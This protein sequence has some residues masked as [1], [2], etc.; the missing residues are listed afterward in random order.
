MTRLDELGLFHMDL[1]LDRMQAFMARAGNPGFPVLHV[2]GTN[3]KGSTATIL[4]ALLQSHGLT[5]GLSTSPHFVSKD[6]VM[7]QNLEI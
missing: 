7:N 2:V 4:A 3:G 1:T 6:G 5:V